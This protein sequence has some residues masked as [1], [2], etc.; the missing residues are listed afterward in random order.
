MN[1]LPPKGQMASKGGQAPDDH[2]HLTMSFEEDAETGAQDADGAPAPEM[3]GDA[4]RAGPEGQARSARAGAARAGAGREAGAGLLPQF[5]GIELSLTVEVGSLS[6]PLKDLVSVEPGQLLALDRMTTEPVSVL[7]NG[8]PFA[9]GE[10]VAVG[11][12]YGVRLLEIVAPAGG[13]G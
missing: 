12:R 10:I 11:D 7:V 13:A 6:I 2:I 8:K 3:A 9:R 1:A 4:P 5:A